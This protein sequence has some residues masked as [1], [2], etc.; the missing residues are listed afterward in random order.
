MLFH[1]T[2]RSLCEGSE[3][4]LFLEEPVDAFASEMELS[5]TSEDFTKRYVAA[6][7]EPLPE[8]ESKAV[9]QDRLDTGWLAWGRK[10]EV[11]HM[12][13]W[14]EQAWKIDESCLPAIE[15]FEAA[16]SDAA[17]WQQVWNPDNSWLMI[18]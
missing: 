10:M 16:I 2:L 4:R 17:W 14:E 11:T 12:S 5:D 8:D 9:L 6:F 13:G 18:V 15:I 7:R 3:E 1:I